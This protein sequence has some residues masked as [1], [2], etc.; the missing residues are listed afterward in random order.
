M[1]PTLTE[2]QPI[3]LQ[4]A[5]LLEDE[6]IQG[7]LPEGEQAPSTNQLAAFYR[8]NPATVLKGINLLVDEGILVKRRGIGMFVAEGARRKLT[9]KRKASFFRDKVAAL[10][11]EAKKIGISPEEV[12]AMIREG[13]RP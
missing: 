4:I 9:E 3:F 5:E 1:K 2:D 6:I 13:Q 10:L 11:D 12:I 7:H 8:I